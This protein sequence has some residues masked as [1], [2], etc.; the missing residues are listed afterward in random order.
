MFHTVRGIFHK[1]FG[2]KLKSVKNEIV[3]V[4]AKTQAAFFTM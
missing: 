2:T 4:S 1:I 3:L